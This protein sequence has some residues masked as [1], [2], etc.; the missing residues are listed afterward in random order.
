MHAMQPNRLDFL[1][2][3]NA[4][5]A[6]PSLGTLGGEDIPESVIDQFGKTYTY[7]G[8][9]PRRWGGAI[10]GDALANGE[11]L[12]RS[13]LVYRLVTLRSHWWQRMFA[14]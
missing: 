14:K 7:V 9:A 8:L 4:Q 11:F 13:G 5:P 2:L 10:D 3:Q 1:H 6:G 12:F